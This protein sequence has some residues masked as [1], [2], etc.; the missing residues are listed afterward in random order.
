[1]RSHVF[2]RKHIAAALVATVVFS[3]PS[4]VLSETVDEMF[5]RLQQ[6]GVDSEAIE[7]QISQEWSKSGSASMDLLL[8]RG[9]AALEAQDSDS[10]IGFL[11]ALVDHA[12]G[13]AEGY[14]ARASAFYSAGLLGP[15]LADIR[16]T[17]ALNPRHFG[18]M[19]GL[20]LI[21]QDTGHPKDALEVWQQ[22]LR[23][24][25]SNPAVIEAIET[26]DKEIGGEAL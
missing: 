16:Q 23:L 4:T 2:L 26:L 25:P 14:N 5:T 17:L 13:F 19:A 21:L 10:A 12:P 11:S 9:M 20:A 15:A 18:A 24:T 3:L 22:V 7:Q 1:M 8:Q 6:P